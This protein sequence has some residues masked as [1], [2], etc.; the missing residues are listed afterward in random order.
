M[1]ASGL[2]DLPPLSQWLDARQAADF[3]GASPGSVHR[4]LAGRGPRGTKLRSLL[5]AGRRKT[6]VIWLDEF[7]AESSSRDTSP[8]A[9]PSPARRTREIERASRELEQEGI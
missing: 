3:L 7:L 5:I 6:N 4:Y 2:D 8:T 9:T 1:N